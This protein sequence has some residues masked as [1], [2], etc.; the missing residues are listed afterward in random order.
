MLAIH[1]SVEPMPNSSSRI[2]LGFLVGGSI[3][4]RICQSV[5][6]NLASGEMEDTASEVTSPYLTSQMAYATMYDQFNRAGPWNFRQ[7]T[8]GVIVN[9]QANQYQVIQGEP[10]EASDQP[11]ARGRRAKLNESAK[12]E[13]KRQSDIKYRQNKK[14]MK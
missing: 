5:K 14:V 1:Q 2:H 13:R 12:R 7:H 8:N 6:L 4:T 9:S 3:S 11:S 10:S